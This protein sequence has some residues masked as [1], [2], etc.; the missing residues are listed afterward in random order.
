MKKPALI[1]SLIIVAI[2][3]LSTWYFLANFKRVSKE[4]DLP[5]TGEP[6]YNPLYALKLSLRAMGQQADSH[7]RLDLGSLT[8]KSGDT[9]LLYSPPNDLS[10]AQLDQ[11]LDWVEAGGHLIVRSP[12][13][14]FLSDDITLFTKLG[15]SPSGMEEDCFSYFGAK[16]K[17]PSVI[18]GDRF[19]TED[20]E[21]FDW[22]HGDE[23]QG[24]S[25]GRMS[26]GDGSV[27]VASSLSFMSNQELNGN[28]ARQMTYQLLADSMGKGRFHLIY[29]TDMSP[30]WLLLLKHGWTLLVPALLLLLAWLVYRSQRFGPLQASPNQ[31]RRA[32]LEHITATGEYMFH[33]HLGHEL[34][35]AVLAL[36]NAKL[37]RR[38][39]MTAA[40]TG[41][42]QIQA[43]V[44]RTGIDPQKIRQALKPGSLQQ[45]ENFF[46]SIATLIQLR[47]Q[48]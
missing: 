2:V 17:M 6:R 47:N 13:E 46:N 37:R 9:L 11:L 10:E 29:A 18:C 42:A 16:E 38:D 21:W 40:L 34:H 22:L 14:L 43:L 12:S 33:R 35:L 15:L 27:T 4:R 44:E 1:I 30:L 45:K 48:L 25:L 31:D 19:Y 20:I 24:Y 3:G 23:E 5:M 7:A 41:E 32:L 39:P 26:W 28:S 36:F 8:L